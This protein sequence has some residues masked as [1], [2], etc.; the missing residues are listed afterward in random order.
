MT[1]SSDT[2]Q[3]EIKYIKSIIFRTLLKKHCPNIVICIVKVQIFVFVHIFKT[4]NFA[5]TW[6][7]LRWVS[8][9]STTKS[10][11]IS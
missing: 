6:F 11:Y 1:S 10:I 2:K 4:V 5:S 9:F 8:V 7:Y 3:Y